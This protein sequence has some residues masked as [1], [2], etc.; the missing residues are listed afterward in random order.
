MTVM[1][2][3]DETRR[4]Y[5]IRLSQPTPEVDP[6]EELSHV[7]EWFFEISARVD[8]AGDGYCKK[9]QLSDYLAW[10]SLTGNIVNPV[11]YD[12]LQSMDDAYC[13]EWNKELEARRKQAAE[14]S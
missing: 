1:P 11:D 13:A 8:R 5:Y 10:Q 4:E 14:K 3:T 6:P 12:I 7:W 9:I 2:K